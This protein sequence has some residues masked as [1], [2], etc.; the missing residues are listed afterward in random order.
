LRREGSRRSEIEVPERDLKVYRR[1]AEIPTDIPI[2]TVALIIWEIK[3]GIR[4]WG[5]GEE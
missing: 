5:G 2:S 4:G 3:R 1:R